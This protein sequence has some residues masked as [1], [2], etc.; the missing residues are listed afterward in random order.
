MLV[1]IKTLP[2]EE[3]QKNKRVIVEFI[4]YSFVKS[5]FDF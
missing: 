4:R 1:K 2:I 3:R 5:S